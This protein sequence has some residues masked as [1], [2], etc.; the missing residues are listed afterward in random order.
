MDNLLR[1]DCSVI[2]FASS[3]SVLRKHVTKAH[4]MMK[5]D[6]LIVLAI[7]FTSL[8]I[9]VPLGAANIQIKIGPNIRVGPEGTRQAEPSIAAH[10]TNSK[11]LIISASEFVPG[12]PSNGLLAQSYI[13]NDGGLTWFVSELPGVREPLSS[14][15]VVTELDTWIV[16]APNGEALYTTLPFT[17]SEKSPIYFF[18]S[19]DNGRSWQGPIEIA[20]SDYDQPSATASLREGGVQVYIAAASRGAVLLSSDDDGRSFHTL[21]HIEPDNLSHQA[22]NPVVLADGSILLPFEDFPGDSEN[23]QLKTSRVYVARSED[24]G[25]TFGVPRFVADIARPYPGGARFAIDLSSGKYRGNV[26]ATWEDGDFGPRL[27]RRGDRLV[28]EESGTRREV[29]VSRSTDRGRTWSAPKILRAEGRGAADFATLAVSRDG[30]IGVLW[31][32]DEKYENNSRCYRVWFAA[33]VDGGN[34]FS[35]AA[36]VSDKTSCSD[37][38]LNPEPAFATRLKGGDYIGLAAAADGSFHAAWIDARD[39][40]FRLYTARL[41]VLQ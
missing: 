26:Y 8:A 13:S 15:R 40:A 1:G 35:A 16:F 14:G 2:V 34:T 19:R 27:V 38:K 39:G 10:P 37:P 25:R 31:A 24:G 21:A 28:R 17:S 12:L 22:M 29:A 20:D 7:V 3:Y 32:Q 5:A 33:S 41:E 6:K 36:S 18:R 23:Q 4:M 9:Y 30:V 11:I